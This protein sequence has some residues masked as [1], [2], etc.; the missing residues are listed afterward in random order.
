MRVYK[1]LGPLHPLTPLILRQY[2]GP[3]NTAYN[4]TALYSY[5]ACTYSEKWWISIVMEKSDE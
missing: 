2:S 1:F 4:D 3:T 5:V